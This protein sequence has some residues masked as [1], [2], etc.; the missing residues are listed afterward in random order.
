MTD[1]NLDSLISELLPLQFMHNKSFKRIHIK[2]L[3]VAS[4]KLG[5]GGK[6]EEKD[7]DFVLSTLKYFQ[8]FYNVHIHIVFIIKNISPSIST[9]LLSV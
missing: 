5:L 1:L 8:I 9:F 2:L 3:A 4:G 7:F 6:Q